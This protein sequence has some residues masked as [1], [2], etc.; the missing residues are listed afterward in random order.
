MFIHVHV[1]HFWTLHVP[2]QMNGL[3]V[4]VHVHVRLIKCDM[5]SFD[6]LHIYSLFLEFRSH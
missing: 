6:M 3:H 4:H 5:V 1:H 2:L